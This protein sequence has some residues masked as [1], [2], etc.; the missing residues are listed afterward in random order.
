MLIPFGHLDVTDTTKRLCNEALDSGRLSSGK[1]VRE[2][3]EK[4]AEVVG[5]KHAVTASSGTNALAMALMV[6]YDYGAER[7][8]TVICPALTFPGTTNAVCQAGFVPEFVDIDRKTLCIDAAQIDS[9][10]MFQAEAIMPV[11]LMG[12]QPDWKALRAIAD[13]EGPALIEDAAESHGAELD[14]IK[15]GA[16]G[17]IAG[18]SLYAAHIISCIE[19]GIATT[20]NEDYAAIMRSIRGDGRACNCKVCVANQGTGACKKRWAS[21][22]DRRFQFDRIGMSCKMT[23]K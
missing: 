18:F 17:D 11:S 20:N 13:D 14:G 19:G 7:G 16:F 6:L 1:L 4:Y 15:A 10:P 21:G 9:I 2:F 5:V 12:K 22:S 3:E 8:N 23:I